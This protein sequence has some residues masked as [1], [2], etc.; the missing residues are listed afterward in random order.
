MT[1]TLLQLLSDH[2]GWFITGGVAALEVLLRL[3]PGAWPITKILSEAFGKV[4]AN[5]EIKK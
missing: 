2:S 3:V 5:R 1:A 4:V